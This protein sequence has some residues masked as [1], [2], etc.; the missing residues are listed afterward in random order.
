MAEIVI[1]ILWF[2][3]FLIILAGVIYLAIWV[4]ENFVHPIP[5]RIK[6][7]VWVVVLLIALIYLITILVGGGGMPAMPKLR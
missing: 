1:G 6:Q 5:E 2:L 4:I 3:V 7:G